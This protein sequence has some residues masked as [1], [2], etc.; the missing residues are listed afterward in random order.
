MSRA[1][2][3]RSKSCGVMMH[4]TANIGR[5]AQFCATQDIRR[6]DAIDLTSSLI[7]HAIST[8]LSCNVTGCS[9]LQNKVFCNAI[10]ST[11]P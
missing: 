6:I 3:D 5:L 1:R 8:R 9:Q 4:D 11:I 7:I 2:A 10:V